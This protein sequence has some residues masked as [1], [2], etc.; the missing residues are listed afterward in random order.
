MTAERLRDHPC[1]TVQPFPIVNQGTADPSRFG[2]VYRTCGLNHPHLPDQSPDMA[3]A[4]QHG[5]DPP[6]R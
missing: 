6:Q 4:N 2:G 3:N 5:V 1:S